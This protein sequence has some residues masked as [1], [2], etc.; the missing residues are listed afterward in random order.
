MRMGRIIIRCCD[1]SPV[2]SSFVFLIAWHIDLAVVGTKVST[3]G[4][5][6]I[7]SSSVTQPPSQQQQPS[8]S[9]TTKKENTRPVDDVENDEN[10]ENAMEAA[11]ANAKIL[12]RPSSRGGLAFDMTFDGEQSRQRAPQRLEKLRTR[13]RSAEMS[14]HELQ[15]KLA[16]AETRRQVCTHGNQC[17]GV[18][19]MCCWLCMRLGLFPRS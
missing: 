4:R 18:G 5:S 14:I 16:A 17:F 10:D 1:F 9:T 19:L 6:S 11:R 15:E 13:T 7:A 8:T 12:E 2:Y 3:R